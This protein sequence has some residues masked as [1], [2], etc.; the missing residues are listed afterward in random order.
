MT[1]LFEYPSS[2]GYVRDSETSMA[3]AESVENVAG[4]LR[5][6]I[7]AFIERRGG[8]TCDEVEAAMDLR[9]QTASARITELRLLGEI[10]KTDAKRA[11]RSGRGA[12]VYRSRIQ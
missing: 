8:A 6:K 2:P 9:H 1:D 3:A 5:A 12:V 7:A 10:E 4:T 11:T